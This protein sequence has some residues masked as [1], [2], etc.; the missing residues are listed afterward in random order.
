MIWSEPL[1]FERWQAIT[2]I[3]LTHK[4]HMKGKLPT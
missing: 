2:N 4:A 3:M 1:G